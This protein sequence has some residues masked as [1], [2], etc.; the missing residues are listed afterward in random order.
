MSHMLEM[1]GWMSALSWQ[2]GVASG[3]YLIGTLIQALISLNRPVYEPERWQ[4]TLFVIGVAFIVFNINVWGAKALPF[5]QNC[6]LILHVCGFAVIVIVLW[7]TARVQS[8]KAVF[9][10][11]ENYGGWNSM[12][13]SL[14]IGQIA[15]V[16]VATCAWSAICRFRDAKLLR[17]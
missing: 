1:T 11:F 10:Q 8:A 13:L 4:G 17:F 3:A 14:M 16:Y 9:T 12:G 5:L 15:A 2:G 6:L 7:V